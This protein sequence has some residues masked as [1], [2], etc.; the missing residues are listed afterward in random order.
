MR[1]I[2]NETWSEYYHNNGNDF[3]KA[4]GIMGG[5]YIAGTAIT[6]ASP[7][8]VSAGLIAAGVGLAAGFLEIGDVQNNANLVVCS[9]ATA[10]ATYAASTIFSYAN[11]YTSGAALLAAGAGVASHAIGYGI[12]AGNHISS[13]IGEGSNLENSTIIVDHQ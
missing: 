4:G 6:F 11:P 10:V 3:M 9:G 8:I 7:V 1:D 12:D 5:L 2:T 13:L